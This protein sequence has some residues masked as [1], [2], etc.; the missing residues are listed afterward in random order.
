MLGE[1]PQGPGPFAGAERL[2]DRFVAESGLAAGEGRSLLATVAL[3]ADDVLRPG[4]S[5]SPGERSRAAIALLSARGVNALVLDEPTNNLDL[6]AIEQLELALASYEGP[7]CSSATTGASSTPSERRRRS[8]SSRRAERAASRRL[9]RGDRDPAA[10][11]LEPFGRRRGHLGRQRADPHADAVADPRDRG[12]LAASRL[13]AESSGVYLADRDVPGVDDHADLALARCRSSRRGRRS[14]AVPVRPSL[15][16]GTCPRSRFAPVNEAT[17]GSLGWEISSGSRAGVAG[18]RPARQ[19]PREGDR[20]LVVVGHDQRRQVEARSSAGAPPHRVLRVG[21]HAASG[22][23][24]SRTPGSRASARAQG[25]AL[26]FAAGE[27]AGLLLREVRDPKA[28]EQ[29]RDRSFPQKATFRWTV[30]CGKS[31]YS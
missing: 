1:L 28:L 14:P 5:L 3:G 9:E 30:R 24:S 11:Q 27:R 17:N 16:A 25:D 2:L 18:P 19:R 7:P 21:V 23:S 6:E 8:S 29:L 4:R 22:S 31:A 15:S 13:S 26:A 10:R 20:V 12:D